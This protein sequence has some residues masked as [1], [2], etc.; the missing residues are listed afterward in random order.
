MIHTKRLLLKPLNADELLLEINNKNQLDKSLNLNSRINENNIQDI[1]V[2]KALE[3]RMKMVI[4]HPVSYEWYTS[5]VLIAVKESVIIGGIMLMSEPKNGEVEIGYGLDDYYQNNGYMTEAVTEL[6]YWM[7]EE[8]EEL[9]YV[10]AETEK[11]NIASQKMLMHAGM[12]KY[13]ETEDCYWWR[14]GRC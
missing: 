13:K 3:Y 9:E 14:I 4:E 12:T 1:H 6:I 7:F 11:D 8:S 5:W 10:I 2:Q